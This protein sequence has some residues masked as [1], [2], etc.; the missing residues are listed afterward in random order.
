MPLSGRPLRMTAPI[1]FSLGIGTDQL[2]SC[3]IGS[4]LTAA[5]F[6]SM[7]EGAILLKRRAAARYR[8]WRKNFVG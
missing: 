5:G 7:A 6:F 3:E 1:F 2:G 8:G 4:A